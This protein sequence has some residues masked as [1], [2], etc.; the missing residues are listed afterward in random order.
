MDLEHENGIH[1]PKLQQISQEYSV[2]SRLRKK[3]LQG[4]NKECVRHHLV[5]NTSIRQGMV[6]FRESD[7][8]RVERP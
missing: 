8:V 2:Y 5:Q 4:P 1:H 7:E 6:S 3:T